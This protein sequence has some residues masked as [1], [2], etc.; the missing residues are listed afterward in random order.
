MVPSSLFI[1]ASSVCKSLRC[2]ISTL[3]QGGEGGHL[4]RLTCSVVLGGGR[5]TTNINGLCGECLQCMDHTGFATAQG[6]VCFLGLHCLGS[7]VLCRALSQVD[8]VFPAYPRSK[9]L[10]FSRTLQGNRPHWRCFFVPLPGPSS[11]D[12]QKL[13]ECTVLGGLCILITPLVLATP[14]YL[15]TPCHLGFLGAPREQHLRYA[16]CLLWGADANHPASQE[17]V[18]RN[19]VPAH[20]LVE[21]A[22]SGALI[23]AAPCLLALAVTCLPLCL[24]QGRG[25]HA[26]SLLSFGIHS[27]PC[28]ASGPG[29]QLEP[30]MGKSVVVVGFFSPFS[31]SIP[32]LGLLS[33]VTSLRLSSS[34][35]HSDPVL[36]PRIDDAACTSLTS[37]H[38]LVAAASIWATSPL[39]VE[40]RCIF[41]TPSPGQVSIPKSFVF[42]FAFYIFSYFL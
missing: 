35:G 10:R 33:H 24:Q 42:L 32:Q 30:F 20:S 14:C 19:W 26:A 9:P 39:G 23:A 15:A 28:S 18:V 5:G 16:V 12:D 6:G 31:L 37:S 4:F 38:L 41:M 40:V 34:S 36:T 13:G 11:S 29:C 17:D 3:V 27:I 1:L 8:P 25:L 21:D 7:R 22:I 2:L